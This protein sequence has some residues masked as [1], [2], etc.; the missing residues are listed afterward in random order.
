MVYATYFLPHCVYAQISQG[1]IYLCAITEAMHLEYYQ[2]FE[3]PE[4]LK[5]LCWH[6]GLLISWRGFL[7]ILRSN[8][9]QGF[10]NLSLNF[11]GWYILKL[12]TN[13]I[14]DRKISLSFLLQF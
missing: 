7:M 10:I 11:F 9:T 6:P 2:G 1:Q 5:Q 8:F 13:L 12:L 4:F 3:I 14:K